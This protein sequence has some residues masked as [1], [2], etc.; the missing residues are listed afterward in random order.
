MLPP[1]AE[2]QQPLINVPLCADSPRYMQKHFSSESA[3]S[4]LHIPE[5]HLEV[6]E[7]L[8]VRQQKMGTTEN[9]VYV[10][11][12][13]VFF[14]IRCYSAWEKILTFR[15]H[16]HQSF[17]RTFW[18][19]F[20]FLAG[21]HSPF[22]FFNSIVYASIYDNYIKKSYTFDPNCWI[23]FLLGK[24]EKHQCTVCYQ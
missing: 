21:R 4:S 19:P 3:F 1:S 12:T 9:T 15:H 11:Q 24:N 20:S 13:E 18:N 14:W 10:T 23:S 7:A 6:Y 16:L 17:P 22:F 2:E 5:I 8:Y